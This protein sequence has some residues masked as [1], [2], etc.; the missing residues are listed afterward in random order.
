MGCCKCGNELS[1]FI[2]VWEI[3]WLPVKLLACLEGLCF[4]GFGNGLSN[5]LFIS[6]IFYFNL[7]YIPDLAV[8]CAKDTCVQLRLAM[9]TAETCSRATSSP[10]LYRKGRGFN[11]QSGELVMV[12]LSRCLLL[13][14]LVTLWILR[15]TP[16]K[17]Q[18]PPSASLP[19]YYLLIITIIW[20]SRWEH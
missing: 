20:R 15:E 3:S 6:Y 5:L 8:C 16:I 10:A 12:I 7:F 17:T 9:L 2:K 11:Y 1:G 19:L 13:F 18:Q 14:L 4:I